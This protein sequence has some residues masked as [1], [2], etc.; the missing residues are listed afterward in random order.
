MEATN[1]SPYLMLLQ[2]GSFLLGTYG[3]V[4]FVKL[5][6]RPLPQQ[7]LL[8]RKFTLL[9]LHF[10]LT[11]L[12]L[13]AFKAAGLTGVLPC[14]PPV[15]SVVTGVSGVDRGYGHGLRRRPAKIVCCVAASA[16]GQCTPGR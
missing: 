13:V 4:I 6:S 3:F 16:A 7:L 8:R 12:Q 5:A 10:T 15:A 2:A 14:V 11:R 9:H 1:A